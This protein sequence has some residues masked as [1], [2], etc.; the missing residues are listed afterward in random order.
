MERYHTSKIEFIHIWGWLFFI[1]KT[2]SKYD[3]G[4]KTMREISTFDMNFI[5]GQH[6][7]PLVLKGY[8]HIGLKARKLPGV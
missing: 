7:C 4:K 5:V 1:L 3:T 2:H 8:A 6:Y